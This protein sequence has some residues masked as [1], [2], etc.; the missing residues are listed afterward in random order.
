MGGV[1]KEHVDAQGLQTG[2]C[3]GI[4]GHSIAL[5]IAFCGILKPPEASLVLGAQRTYPMECRTALNL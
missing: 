2:C 1:S 5:G 3:Q 4:L